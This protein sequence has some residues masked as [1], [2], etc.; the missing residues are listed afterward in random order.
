MRKPIALGISDFRKLR[1]EGAEYV[2]K[3]QLIIDILDRATEV[4]LLPRPRRFG[5]TLNLS[6]LR[7][8]F[9]RRPEDF[10]H[11]FQDLAVWEAGD[12]Y[13]RHFQRYPVVF[14]TF[15]DVKA[16]T[17][18]GCW[19]DV[20]KKIQALYDEHRTL[21]DGGALSELERRDYEAI[22][23]G[24]AEAV[25][26]RQ[27]LGQ[28]SR[29]L[30][31][32]T[33]ERA[34]I[35]IDEYD[36]PI[37]AGFINGY[38]REV[39]DFFRAFLTVGLKDNPHL[40]RGVLTGILRVSRESIFSGLNNISVYTLL[41]TAFSTC[42]GFTEAEVER[43]LRDAGLLAHR[44]AVREWYNGYVFGSTVVYNPWS[45]LSFIERGGQAKPY[46]LNTSS[47]DL[48]K[49]LLEG[50]AT[51][52]QDI[53]ERLLEGGGVERLLDENVVLDQLD[54]NDD[55]L[56]SLLVFSG[57]LRAEQRPVEDPRF[58]ASHWLTIPNLEVRSLY[59]GTFRVWLQSGLS[60]AGGS[61]ER[62]LR[63]VLEG[64]AEELAYQL[65]A[66]ARN[67]LSYHDV[68]RVRPEEIY[69]SFV[70]GL[71]A[72]LEPGHRVRSNR[73]SGKG[74][75]DVLIFPAKPRQPGVV[76]ELKVARGKKTLDDALD[77][78]MAQ[79][80][81]KDYAAELVVAGAEPVHVIVVAFDGKEVRARSGAD[82]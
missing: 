42:F 31:Q 39:I 33:G 59:T 43:L 3:S 18:D 69:Q 12:A 9:E 44:D 61:I 77:E 45:V 34:M 35:L 52:L 14:L 65:G 21:L 22:L 6:M 82:M 57:Y 54:Q 46:W 16:A 63:A 55:A 72:A 32:A 28:L 40:A 78:G 29:H 74:R 60:A 64:D 17:F 4:L 48:I 66:F 49:A 24:T 76:L 70:L 10:S 23:D 51:R 75:P 15:R 56:W 30:H 73:E 26:Y 79:V 41:D 13:R 19:A 58:A 81:S 47:N 37:H 53:F 2:D 8:F 7:C 38:F 67:L 25:L 50:R 62:L 20:K 27:A 80:R 11:L 71:L 36:Q 5:K 68:G 1:E